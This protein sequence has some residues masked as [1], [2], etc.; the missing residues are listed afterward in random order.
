MAPGKKDRDPKPDRRGASVRAGTGSLPKA[1]SR[2][3][4]RALGE[5]ARRPA[6][7]PQETHAQGVQSPAPYRLLPLETQ[8]LYAE[9]LEHL[10]GA[11]FARVAIPRTTVW[12]WMRCLR[13]TC[14]PRRPRDAR[15]PEARSLS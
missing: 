11:E 12:M 14:F 8:T 13:P 2:A 1:S 4:S 3:G 15:P 5:A 10:R 7:K 6:G 9:L